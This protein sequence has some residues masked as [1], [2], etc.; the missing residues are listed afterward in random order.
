[1]QAEGELNQEIGKRLAGLRSSAGLTQSELAREVSELGMPMAQQTIA[2]IESGTRPL[3]LTE[4]QILSVALHFDIGSLV[5]TGDPA[6]LELRELEAFAVRCAVE[7][8]NATR[9][10]AAARDNLLRSLDQLMQFSTVAVE[11][12]DPR[13]MMLGANAT[14]RSR[15]I[16][17]ESGL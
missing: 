12:G 11:S 4:A 2:K 7:Y 5:P 15:S 13:R 1:M 10:Y 9:A 14:A 8:R 3:K 16:R 6:E 17:K